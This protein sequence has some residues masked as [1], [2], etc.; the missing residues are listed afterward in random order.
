LI[1]ACPHAY[2][3][4]R[5]YFQAVWKRKWWFMRHV[6]LVHSPVT[7]LTAVAVIHSLGLSDR[8]AVIIFFEFEKITPKNNQ[9][10]AVSISEFYSKKT[11]LKIYN[12]FKYFNVIKRIDRL[13]NSIT[14]NE[15]YTAYVPVLLF[16]GKALI[17]NS[18]C[19]AFNFIEEGLID[20][21]K[22][23]T[24]Q[25]L[26]VI[27]AREP[28]R[29]DFLK[30]TKLVLREIYEVLR[31]YNFRL[32]ALPFSYSCYNGFKNVFY[33]GFSKDSFPLVNEERRIIVP[34]E[35]NIFT[36]IEQKQKFDLTDQTIWIGDGAV[37][38]YGLNR[39]L[40]LKGIK[41]GCV[42]YLKQNSIQ[43]IFIKFHRDEPQD[44]RET[45]KALFINNGIN[46]QTIPDNV[47][48]ELLLFKSSNTT[49]IGVF[50][51]LLYYAAIMNHGA[52]SVYNFLKGEYAR[53]L[54]NRDFTF[55]WKK[56]K[57]LDTENSLAI[58]THTNG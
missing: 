34:F 37:I 4:K 16:A 3:P 19:V 2:P 44:L 1:A 24:L 38:Q 50:S 30:N 54:T 43:N 48:M 47:I 13:V 21:Y 20:Y 15:K 52:L 46:I 56:V 58:T 18:N 27:K 32:Q 11:Y 6:F 31:G 26:T 28:W 14:K 35:K 8:D 51:S 41:E 29:S 17:T 45:I 5:C 12:Y 49:L 7:Y 39:E 33:Y 22:E 53:L 42:Q 40:Y 57:L 9:Y 55:Y 23:E 10:V 36:D 25:S